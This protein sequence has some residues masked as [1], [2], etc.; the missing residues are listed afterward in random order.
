[1]LDPTVAGILADLA[2]A[3]EEKI[4]EN[5][6]ASAWPSPAEHQRACI[7]E[8]NDEE[9]RCTGQ[10]YLDTLEGQAEDAAFVVTT[11]EGRMFEITV[12][13]LTK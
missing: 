2:A 10:H 6:T 4:D 12:T 1:M 5:S 13:E 7:L 9:G 8:D 3:V 11:V